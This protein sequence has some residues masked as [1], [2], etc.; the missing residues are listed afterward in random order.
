MT[1]RMQRRG[2]WMDGWIG[3]KSLKWGRGRQEMKVKKKER[4]FERRQHT[5]GNNRNSGV[6][7]AHA[8]SY[9]R[10]ACPWTLHTWQKKRHHCTVPIA[11][12]ETHRHPLTAEDL[13]F[14]T[15][16]C[17]VTVGHNDLEKDTTGG[18]VSSSNYLLCNPKSHPAWVT[19][20]Q[21]FR[22]WWQETIYWYS[23]PKDWCKDVFLFCQEQGSHTYSKFSLALI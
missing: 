23:N 4:E 3:E 14:H 16:Q 8:F 12:T 15:Q 13:Y 17:K 5:S 11:N 6:W 1:H 10:T 18:K 20:S 9:E 7:H 22:H 21:T 19:H 2:G